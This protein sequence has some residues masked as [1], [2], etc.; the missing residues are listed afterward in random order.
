VTRAGQEQKPRKQTS[1]SGGQ[2]SSAAHTQPER[3]SVVR[4][5]IGQTSA[6]QPRQVQVPAPGA[7]GSTHSPSAGQSAR[8]SH[9]P[10]VQT[11]FVQA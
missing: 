5:A 10:P 7:D 2:S 6:P 1:S 4:Q 11:P 3:K 8:R 9:V